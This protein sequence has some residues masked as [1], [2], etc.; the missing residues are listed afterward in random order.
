MAWG[1]AVSHEKVIRRLLDGCCRVAILILLGDL[2]VLDDGVLFRAG[3]MCYGYI[4]DLSNQLC[5]FAPKS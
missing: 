5:S 2:P 1:L 3:G 4:C